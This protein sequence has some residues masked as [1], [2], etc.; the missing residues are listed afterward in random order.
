MARVKDRKAV[1]DKVLEMV[2]SGL[3]I[4]R[5]CEWAGITPAAFRNWRRDD[6][7]LS[8]ALKKAEIEFEARHLANIT[9]AASESWQASAWILERKFKKRYAKITYAHEPKQK[10]DD[11][12]EAAVL[13]RIPTREEFD[14]TVGK[15]DTAIAS[16]KPKRPRKPKADA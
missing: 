8:C 1:A 9:A 4:A 6:V 16:L 3:T 12:D 14:R 7:S 13:I 10:Q 5:A 15:T 11:A 2:S